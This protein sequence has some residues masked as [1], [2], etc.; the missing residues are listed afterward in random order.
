M[1]YT[2]LGVKRK[3]SWGDVGGAVPESGEDYDN[4]TVYPEIHAS[5]K[6]AEL[7]GAEELKAGEE[8]EVPVVLKVKNH[9][10]TVENGKTRYSM[11]LCVLRMGEFTDAGGGDDYA[12]DPSDTETYADGARVVNL[13]NGS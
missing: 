10:K 6:L 7:M 13:L 4:E 9:S 8:I 5:G 11:T 3:D 2:D 12:D 1:D